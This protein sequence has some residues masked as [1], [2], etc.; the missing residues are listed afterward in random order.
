MSA[1]SSVMNV[2]RPDEALLGRARAIQ[3]GWIE[4]C[5][6]D[7]NSGTRHRLTVRRLAAD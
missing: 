6:E 1:L 5:E 4:S 7:D 2:D 3:I